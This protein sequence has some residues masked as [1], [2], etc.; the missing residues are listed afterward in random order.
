MGVGRRLKE[1]SSSIKIVGVEPVKGHKIQGLKNMKEAIVPGIFKPA[2]LD[3]KITIDDETAY[4]A[5][6][7]LALKEGLFVGCRAGRRWRAR[8]CLLVP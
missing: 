4:D 1:H 5:A 3:D 6:R 2:N 7:A 8:L